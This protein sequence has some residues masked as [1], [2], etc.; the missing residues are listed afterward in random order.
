[1]S[2]MDYQNWQEASDDL[3]SIA[4]HRAALRKRPHEIISL[5]IVEIEQE[6]ADKSADEKASL[7][8]MRLC[9]HGYDITPL[10]MNA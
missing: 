1:M 7:I 3:S 10:D 9:E 5:A 6:Y 2:R 4:E 8:R